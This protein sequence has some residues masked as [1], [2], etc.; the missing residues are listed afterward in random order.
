[1]GMSLSGGRRQRS[2]QAGQNRRCFAV[3]AHD[4]VYRPPRSCDGQM[5]AFRGGIT[6]A[7]QSKPT[8]APAFLRADRA[9]EA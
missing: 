8:A 3:T 5:V 4:Q 2:A 6:A 9:I 7:K 1:M